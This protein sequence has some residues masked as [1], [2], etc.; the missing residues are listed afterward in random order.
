[1]ITEILLKTALEVVIGH[2]FKAVIESV[3]ANSHGKS[4]R[5]ILEAVVMEVYRHGGQI[6][7]LHDRVSELEAEIRNLRMQ[8]LQ[9]SAKALPAPLP[10]YGTG[11]HFQAVAGGE[12]AYFNRIRRT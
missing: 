9:S 12:M 1:M 8:G 6:G 5:Q 4:D 10:A 7:D 11:K 3:L 2:G